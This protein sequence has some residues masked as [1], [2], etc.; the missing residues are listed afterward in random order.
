MTEKKPNPDT[1]A[2]AKKAGERARELLQ[3]YHGCAQCT[4]VALQ[5]VC[6]M[7]DEALSKASVLL[8]G[9]VGGIQSVCGVLTGA[10]LALGIKY[11]RDTSYLKG[12]EEDAVA[13]ENEGMEIAG[14]LC[15]WFEREFGTTS[16]REIRRNHMG[17]DLSNAIPWQK[18]IAAELDMRECCLKIAEKTARRTAAILDDPNL[19]I[20][21]EI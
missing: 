20:L 3:T 19:G 21:D 14:K 16:C 13:K 12:T 17:T 1:A 10:C 2:K 11:G 9:G 15:K 6:G 4:L 5:Q 18:E 7:E 8:S